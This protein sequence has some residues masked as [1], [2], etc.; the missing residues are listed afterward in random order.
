MKSNQK[1]FT[2]VEALILFIVLVIVVGTGI[3]IFQYNN[4][5][6]NTQHLEVNMPDDTPPYIF[7]ISE[8]KIQAPY[9][10]EQALRYTIDP[11]DPN[12][13]GLTS[14]QL[15]NADSSCPSNAAGSIE[16]A[17]AGE[18]SVLGA[19]PQTPEQYVQSGAKYYTKIGSYYYFFSGP[20]MNC[21]SESSVNIIQKTTTKEIQNLMSKFVTSK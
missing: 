1:G 12:E 9:H 16:R 18:Q 5:K 11:S 13:A 3:Y 19:I 20:Q 21:S 17:Q 10:G 14:T 2:L 6:D 15:V 8:W 4:N 7:S